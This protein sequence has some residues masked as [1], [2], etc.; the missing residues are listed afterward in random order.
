MKK[1][2]VT[3]FFI[4]CSLSF[5]EIK[6]NVGLFSEEDIKNIT[7]VIE[8]IEKEKDIKVYLN[9]VIGEESFQLVTPQ[10]TFIITYQKIGKDIIVTELKFTED[11]K[12]GD[13]DQEIDLILD[14]LKDQLF[15]KQYVAYT[16]SLLEQINTLI[17]QKEELENDDE[18]NFPEDS[19]EVKKGFFK[20]IFSKNP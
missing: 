17:P 5:G 8:K 6:D 11:L 19:G 3:V 18:E 4:I 1:I 13:K 9:T 15:E 2:I 10:K 14:S 16:T 20:R 12:M 7:T